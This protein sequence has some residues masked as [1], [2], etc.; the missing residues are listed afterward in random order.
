MSWLRR[1][2]LAGFL[3]NQARRLRIMKGLAR[4]TAQAIAKNPADRKLFE[5]FCELP[6]DIWRESFGETLAS[7]HAMR[8]CLDQAQKAGIDQEAIL[9]LIYEESRRAVTN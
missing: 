7:S 9:R 8:H 2:L 6:Y 3:S 4:E 5:A 1:I